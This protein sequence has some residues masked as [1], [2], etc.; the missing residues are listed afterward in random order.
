MKNNIFVPLLKICEQGKYL[1]HKMVKIVV[2]GAGL[3]GLSVGYHA[4]RAKI[5]YMIY[6]QNNDVGG[7]CSTKEKDGFYFDHSGHLLHLKN[8]YFQSLVKD[9]LGDNLNSIHRHSFIYSKGV[10]TRYP[11]QANLYGLPPEVIKECLEEFV[12]AYYENE[13]LPSESYKSFYDWVVSKLGKGIGKHFMFP[14]NEKIWTVSTKELTCEWLSEYVPR[15]ELED[16]FTGS[17]F[18]QKKDFGYNPTFLYPKKGGIQALCYAFAEKIP[19]IQLNEEITMINTSRKVIAF[20][21]GRTVEYEKLIS[22]LSLKI[23]LEKIIEDVPVEV[24]QA[25]QKLRHNSI[26]VVNLGVKGK[27]LTDKH[28]VY[29][30]EKRYTAY[31]V[32]VYSNFSEQMSPPDTT[33]YYVEIAYQKDW[34]IQKEQITE[35]AVN[36]MLEMGFIP[37][38]ED[39]LVKEIFDVDCAYVIYDKNYSEI[40]RVILD[41]LKKIDIYSI[42]RYGS[43]EYSGM[44]DAIQQGKEIID[45]FCG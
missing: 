1:N 14:Y 24:K 7:L 21:S 16:V 39:I 45:C 41:Y 26:I 37:K 34:D 31:R 30:P 33:S 9:L 32:G 40:K 19:N 28:W 27:D 15:P 38:L 29:I 17:F 25:A 44:E 35:K 8:P 36:E 11:F 12:K 5:D 43:W 22:T 42:G 2:I 13:D 6:E 23:L 18:D 20:D 3:A 4:E 10:F